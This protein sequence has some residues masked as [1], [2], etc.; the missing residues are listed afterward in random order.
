MMVPDLFIIH[1]HFLWLSRTARQR[2]SGTLAGKLLLREALDADGA[3]VLVAASVAGCASLCADADGALLREGLRAGFCDF[4][5]G[6][7]DE[8]LRILK[9]EIRRG[10][11]VSVGLTADP[12]VCLRAMAE[13]GAQPDLLSVTGDPARAQIF[14]ERGAVVLPH[15]I[16]E[17]DEPTGETALLCWSVAAEAGRTMPQ[18]GRIAAEALDAERADTPARRR[19]LEISPRYL[20][21]AFAGRQCVRMTETEAAAFTARVRYEVPSARVERGGNRG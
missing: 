8:A 15:V 4:V 16:S 17:R 21:R 5:V 19:W 18:I 11:P 7:L 10:L 20:G 13:R 1:D 3:A 14:V 2:F 6:H 9:N 12:E